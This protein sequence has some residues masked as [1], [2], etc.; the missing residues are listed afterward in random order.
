M[1]SSLSA[2]LLIASLYGFSNAYELSANLKSVEPDLLNLSPE[3]SIENFFDEIERPSSILEGTKRL[4]PALQAAEN[5]PPTSGQ[6]IAGRISLPATNLHHPIAGYHG[7]TS[8]RISDILGEAAGIPLTRT[9]SG[10]SEASSQQRE[11]GGIV[12]VSNEVPPDSRGGCFDFEAP[13]GDFILQSV[14]LAKFTEGDEIPIGISLFTE[15]GCHKNRG[16]IAYLELDRAADAEEYNMDLESMQ[17][18]ISNQFSIL[19]VYSDGDTETALYYTSNEDINEDIGSR[20]GAPL[21]INPPEDIDLDENL[22]AEDFDDYI[23][24]FNVP[25]TILSGVE[26][27]EEEKREATPPPTTRRNRPPSWYPNPRLQAEFPGF[28]IT[29]GTPRHWN[30]LVQ[31]SDDDIDSAH[32]A[33]R[34]D[35]GDSDTIVT[36]ANN[37]R[38]V[39]SV[40]GGFEIGDFDFD[41][42]EDDNNIAIIDQNNPNVVQ[43]GSEII[44][45]GFPEPWLWE[46]S[47]D[48]RRAA[49][50]DWQLPENR[51]EASSEDK[52]LG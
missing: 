17:Q 27:E 7:A 5:D 14:T 28:E 50:D 19:P 26:Q 52:G 1:W 11:E 36:A 15:P 3:D 35:R 13:E 25:W 29:S 30:S 8:R 18:H 49:L 16:Y 47:Q 37:N 4:F 32:V 12:V 23:R 10:K 40:E 46:L 48:P 39:Q 9:A 51:G 2:W 20:P 34:G 33:S 22:L 43:I 38:V 44:V 42:G 31:D 45:R 21:L 41:F 24:D 6:G